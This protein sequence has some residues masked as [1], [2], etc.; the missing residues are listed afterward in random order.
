MRIA[1]IAQ[2]LKIDPTERKER[3]FGAGEKGRHAEQDALN[4]DA[5]H[6][7]PVD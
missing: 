2:F 1:G 6:Q 7:F 4:Q 5:H 3:R